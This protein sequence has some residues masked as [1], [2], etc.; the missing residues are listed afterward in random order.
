MPLY[1][2]GYYI[3]LLKEG[4]KYGWLNRVRLIGNRAVDLISTRLA[5]YDELLSKETSNPDELYHT[6][7]EST[8]P[9]AS[10]FLKGAPG[11]QKMLS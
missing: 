5:E 4:L 11:H 1:L 7:L 8:T 10:V 3:D 2:R 6:I 9:M